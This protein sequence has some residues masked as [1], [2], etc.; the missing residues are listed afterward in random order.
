MYPAYKNIYRDAETFILFI[1]FAG[2]FHAPMSFL[3]SSYVER[4]MYDWIY[5]CPR[6]HRAGL[7]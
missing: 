2:G 6:E 5:E 7:L 4:Q 3:F 1:P